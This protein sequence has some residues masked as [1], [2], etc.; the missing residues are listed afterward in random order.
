[1]E[2]LL[3][4]TSRSDRSVRE[5]KRELGNGLVLG[6]GA[7]HGVL[8]EGPDL[9]R[10]HLMLSQ[11]GANI[12]VTDTSVNG[13]WLNG[14]RLRRSLKTLLQPGDS[15]EV[16]GYV[17][18]VHSAPEQSHAASEASAEKLPHQATPESEVA[19]TPRQ[20]FPGAVL[21]P[22]FHFT[23]SFTFMEKFLVVVGLG[24]LALIVTYIN[25]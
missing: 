14:T 5:E 8:L 25:S 7:E 19:A 20:L 22:V 13:T 10:E 4:I 2:I 9:S 17:L 15:V 21:D 11:E 12:Y 3:S 24:G 23:S 18:A 1:M 16:P 6:R